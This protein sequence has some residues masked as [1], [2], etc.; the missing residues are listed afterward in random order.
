M[1]A[2]GMLLGIPEEDQGAVRE[3]IDRGLHVSRDR[4]RP[5]TR[6]SEPMTTDIRTIHRLAVEHPSDDLMTDLIKAEF[7]RRT[8]VTRRTLTREK[9]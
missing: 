5:E 9:S 6:D 7:D 2:I 8:G 3:R 1:R 4:R